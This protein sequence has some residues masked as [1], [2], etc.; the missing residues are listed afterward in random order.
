MTSNVSER[1]IVDA[2]TEPRVLV[3]YI[4]KLLR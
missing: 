1:I 2:F 3:N 4:E